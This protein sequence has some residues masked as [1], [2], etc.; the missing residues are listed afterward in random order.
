MTSLGIRISGLVAEC[1]VAINVT[2]A[3]FPADAPDPGEGG[4]LTPSVPDQTFRIIAA[5]E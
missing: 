1:I 5:N 4:E 2:R 3:R